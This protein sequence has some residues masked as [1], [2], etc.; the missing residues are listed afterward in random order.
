MTYHSAIGFETQSQV[1]TNNLGLALSYARMGIP[2]FPAKDGSTKDR[3]GKADRRPWTKRGHLDA[4]MDEE[5]ISRWWTRHPSAVPALPMGA[6]SGL[7][8]LD[9]DRKGGKDDVSAIREAHG[10][11]AESPPDGA[12]VVETPSTG[13]HLIFAHAN[14]VTNSAMHLPEGCDIRGEGGWIVAPGAMD[15]RGKYKVLSGDLE[16]GIML[17]LL[18]SFPKVL[19]APERKQG[20]VASAHGHADIDE[21]KDALGYIPHDGSEHHWSSILRGLCHATGGSETGL[22]LAL[23]WSAVYEGFSISEVTSKWHSY[24]R[25]LGT[26][27]NPITERTIFAEARD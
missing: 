14:G 9:L 11:D 20:A 7:A 26:V 1:P 17:D 21:M 19:R 10:L 27:E 23:G 6:A 3:N 5:Q 15:A 18:P 12:V 13:R 16:L 2:V 8:C 22:G 4:T 24:C 25:K